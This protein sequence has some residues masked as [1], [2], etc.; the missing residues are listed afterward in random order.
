MKDLRIESDAPDTLLIPSDESYIFP[1]TPFGALEKYLHVVIDGDTTHETT[2]RLVSS[3]SGRPNNVTI[4]PEM[5]TATGN[6]IHG[7]HTIRLYLT[8]TIG[9][10]Q[11]TTDSINREYIWYD[12]TDTETPVIMASPY[13]G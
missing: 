6:A 9:G 8:A 2:V 10:I 5:I 12:A 13:N 11:Q 7:A 3:T 1:Y 4:T